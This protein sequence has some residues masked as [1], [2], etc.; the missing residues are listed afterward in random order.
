MVMK[1]LWIDTTDGRG[2]VRNPDITDTEFAEGLEE[3]KNANIATLWQAAHDYEYAEIS[4]S[5]IGLLVVGVLQGKSKSLAVREWIDSIWT[6]YYA[7]KPL[8]Q[9]QLDPAL[10]DF[11]S[12]GPMPFTVP[13]LRA[14]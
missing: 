11:T 14:E 7:R 5:A 13:E 9:A 6:L 8:V 3:M 10:L 1:P 12:C 4:G 2:P